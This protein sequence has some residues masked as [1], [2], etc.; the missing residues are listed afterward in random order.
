MDIF[1]FIH[2]G[3]RAQAIISLDQRDDSISCEEPKE[4]PRD[5]QEGDAR[6][7]HHD[8]QQNCERKPNRYQLEPILFFCTLPLPFL[9]AVL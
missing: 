4:L 9:V 5:E 6:S 8:K 2:M 7:C 1:F 3:S